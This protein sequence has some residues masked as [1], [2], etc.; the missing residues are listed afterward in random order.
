[1]QL[2]PSSTKIGS[3]LI[4]IASKMPCV[5]SFSLTAKVSQRTCRVASAKPLFP[6]RV[7]ITN[8]KQEPTPVA[9]NTRRVIKK[10][11]SRRRPAQTSPQGLGFATVQRRWGVRISLIEI[12]SRMPCVSSSS[13]YTLALGE[14]RKNDSS[15]SSGMVG[16]GMVGGGR[17]AATPLPELPRQSPRQSKRHRRPDSACGRFSHQA[18]CCVCGLCVL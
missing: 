6:K 4:E 2:P 13:Q 17:I 14:G 11:T 3:R 7:R 12:A 5:S 10:A 9:P 8:D 16:G 15:D 1:M 18:A